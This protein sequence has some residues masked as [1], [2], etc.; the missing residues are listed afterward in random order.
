MEKSIVFDGAFLYFTLY[1]C[2]NHR[3]WSESWLVAY[4]IITKYYL[5]NYSKTCV[6]QPLSK[7]QKIVIQYQLKREHSAILSTFIK[8]PFAIKIFVLSIFEWPFYTGFTVCILRCLGFPNF[9][10]QANILVLS[11]YSL[12]LSN[13]QTTRF[14]K[15]V[16]VCVKRPVNQMQPTVMTTPVLMDVSA[17]MAW[18]Y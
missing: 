16:G 15:N 5:H 17:Q 18:Y 12:Q 9:F 13:V 8:L 4:D 3:L 1:V 6:K 14:T 7:R 11:L 10:G 2:K